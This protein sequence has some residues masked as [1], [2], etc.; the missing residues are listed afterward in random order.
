MPAH[1]YI[2]PLEHRIGAVNADPQGIALAPGDRFTL[3]PQLGHH[4][5]TVMRARI[6]QRVNCFDGQGNAFAVDIVAIR[7]RQVEVEV[8]ELLPSPPLQ[9]HQTHLVLSL[10]KGQAMDRALQL[11]TEVGADHISLLPAARSN[12]RLPASI[13]D[14]KFN[15]WQRVLVS[16]CEQSGRFYLPSLSLAPSWSTL[17]E[18]DA[19]A[20]TLALDMNGKRLQAA[21]VAQSVRLLIGPEGG[22]APQELELFNR[23]EIPCIRIV[24]ATLRAETAPGIALALVEYL[25][26]EAGSTQP[27]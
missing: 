6:G 12:A 26:S 25:R 1:F 17:L 8:T 15:H 18:E 7:K 24:Q 2:S 23:H 10:L 22:W 14:K 11:A 21:D 5:A 20:T 9:T 3:A 27:D 19:P 16:A 4:L 13:E